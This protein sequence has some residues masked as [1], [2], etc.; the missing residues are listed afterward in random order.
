MKDLHAIADEFPLKSVL[1][2]GDTLL[3]H[4][5]EGT[6][7]RMSPE[8]PIPIISVEKE[9]CAPGGAGNTAVNLK[10]L[11]AN[12][13]RLVGMIGNDDRGRIVYN[14]LEN[15]FVSLSMWRRFR[16]IEKMRGI[17][18]GKHVARFDV[19]TIHYIDQ[20]TETGIVYF[21][22]QRI[23]TSNIVLVSDYAKGFIT[24]SMARELVRIAKDQQK[25]LVVDTKPAHFKWFKGCF[26]IK[27]NK[28]EAEEFCGM[29]IESY[30]DAEK[31]GN[32]IKKALDTNVL[33]TLGPMGMMLFEYVS[34]TR[35]TSNAKEVSDVTGAGD[36]VLAAFGLSLASGASLRQATDI[37]NHAAG[38][39]V[40]K[41]G[42][43]TVTL[44]ELKRSMT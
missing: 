35:F 43:A 40:G 31:A 37:A 20:A 17:A 13:V 15:K 21:L 2:V 33:L 22:P 38:I 19:E 18:G 26:C 5:F 41:Q 3:D 30:A 27:P 39:V 11:G 32:M 9:W 29:K 12:E 34:V 14:L 10:A 25:L 6:V 44:G 28:T 24:E 1:V 7:A 4:Y 16:T 23:A 36:T 8:A 42:T